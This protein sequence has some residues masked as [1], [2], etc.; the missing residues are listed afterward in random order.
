MFLLRTL[1]LILCVRGFFV[2][3]S[4]KFKRDGGGVNDMVKAKDVNVTRHAAKRAQER[5]SWSKNE[6]ATK[7]SLAL[8]KGT[9]VTEDEYLKDLFKNTLVFNKHSLLYYHDGVVFVFDEDR[10]VTIYPLTGRYSTKN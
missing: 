4:R 7:A 9:L 2:E 1:I 10:L 5:F 8:N 3:L 6:L